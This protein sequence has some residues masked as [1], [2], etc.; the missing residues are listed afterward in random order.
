MHVFHTLL[1]VHL[2]ACLG[3]YRGCGPAMNAVYTNNPLFCT[4]VDSPPCSA[5][6]SFSPFCEGWV[7]PQSAG[8]SMQCQCGCRIRSRRC[9]LLSCTSALTVTVKKWLCV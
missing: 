7:L 8:R 3:P 6:P 4:F 2:P 9:T 5:Y 1:K